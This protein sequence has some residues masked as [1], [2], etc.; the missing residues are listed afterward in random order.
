MSTV[1]ATSSFWHYFIV[2]SN[3]RMFLF[4]NQPHDC[5]IDR[6]WNRKMWHSFIFCKWLCYFYC[7][8]KWLS[9]IS[10]MAPSFCY[11]GIQRQLH[12]VFKAHLC[13][14]LILLKQTWIHSICASNVDGLLELET[15]TKGLGKWLKKL[16]TTKKFKRI[17]KAWTIFEL[18]VLILSSLACPMNQYSCKCKCNLAKMRSN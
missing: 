4:S 8:D 1:E 14:K 13:C 7:S 3:Q 6:K 18:Y 11:G 12:I 16:F 15:L 2:K 5:F 9:P 17:S 10:L